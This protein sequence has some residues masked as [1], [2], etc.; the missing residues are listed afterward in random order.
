MCR[1]VWHLT[2]SVVCT[3]FS[4]ASSLPFCHAKEVSCLMTKPTKWH[5][6]PAKTDKP[7][8]P[9]SLISVI[10]VSMKKTW[11]LSYP[12]STQRRLIRLGR[13][14]RLI[15]VF[16]GCTVFVGFVMRRLKYALISF[17]RFCRKYKA[18]EAMITV[19]PYIRSIMYFGSK[20]RREEYRVQFSV[21][22]VN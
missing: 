5:V 6:C 4:W 20:I 10:T 17:C 3:L 13:M 11:V 16:A 22:F 15:W 7:G 9:P 18:S 19:K 12:L 1:V 21:L 8:H 2:V 14:P